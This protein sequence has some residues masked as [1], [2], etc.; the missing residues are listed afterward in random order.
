MLSCHDEKLSHHPTTFTNVLLHQLG[1]RH[2]NELAIRMMRDS[3]R[4]QRLSCSRWTVQQDTF[5][6][7]D[8][9]RFEEFGVFDG[10]LDDFFDF[11][12]LLVES[13]YHLVRA[14]G[15]FLDHHEGDER[16]DFVGEDLV[17]CVGVTAK[18]YA[19][20]G[21]EVSDVNFRVE[22]DDCQEWRFVS[23]WA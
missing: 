2:P 10:K 12:D 6:L 5:R 4:Q 9:E 17:N 16:V 21:L 20:G 22:V 23:S 11:L 13:T 18:G 8:T 7:G 14:V 3:S 15:N 19:E 1:P